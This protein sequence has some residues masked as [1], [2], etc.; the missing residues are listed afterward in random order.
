M[1]ILFPH[2]FNQIEVDHSKDY[3]IRYSVEIIFKFQYPL[4]TFHYYLADKCRK[5]WLSPDYDGLLFSFM[6]LRVLT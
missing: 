2:Y 3:K 6:V 1:T 4:Q 5:P